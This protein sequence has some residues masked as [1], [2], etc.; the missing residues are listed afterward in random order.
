VKG[1]IGHPYTDGIAQRRRSGAD[2]QMVFNDLPQAQGGVPAPVHF[3]AGSQDNEFLPPVP[4]GHIVLT[5]AGSDE[6]GKLNEHFVSDLVAMGIV[7]PLKVVDI[8]HQDTEAILGGGV[9]GFNEIV[10]GG[11][12]VAPGVQ[13]GQGIGNGHAV[14]AGIGQGNPDLLSDR[15]NQLF[16]RSAEM[17]AGFPLQA[18][19]AKGDI[20]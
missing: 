11:F 20:F 5:D 2:E 8:Q 16:F 1:E 9:M 19:K 3:P 13:L 6:T 7:H 10:D 17:M 14:Q 4:A 18:D 12:A 15:E